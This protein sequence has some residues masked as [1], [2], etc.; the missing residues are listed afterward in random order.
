MIFCFSFLSFVSIAKMQFLSTCLTESIELQKKIIRAEKQL[1]LLNPVSTTLQTQLA[2]ATAELAVATAS[3]NAP[4]VAKALASLAKIRS[5][6]LKLS[7]LQSS[8]ILSTNAFI[9]I[10]NAVILNKIQTQTFQ[11][12]QSWF[13]YF[14]VFF[15]VRSGQATEM[16]IQP[17]TSGL[18]PNYE[19][20]P[21]YKANQTVAYHWQLKY[22]TKNESQKL[23]NSQNSF[24]LS[25][26]TIPERKADTW[27]VEIQKDRY[28]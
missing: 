7:Q 11:T 18:A 24:L 19:L 2:V 1:F 15:S 6:Q 22:F 10:G 13:I 20:K 16:A 12:S 17:Q 26:G 28:Y 14:K 25:C 4:A 21:T 9:K 8:I 27:S 23:L 3:G 5:D